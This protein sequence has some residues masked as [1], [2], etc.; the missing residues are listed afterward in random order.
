MSALKD[1]LDSKA[2]TTGLVV[3][4][5]AAAAVWAFKR[6]GAVALEKVGT[7]INPADSDNLANQAV[8][9]VGSV[10]TGDPSWS[11]GGAIFDW[12]NRGSA[13]DYDGYRWSTAE[14]R[15]TQIVQRST[16]KIF[17]VSAS[18]VMTPAT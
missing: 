4:M 15:Y 6:Y 5:L 17:N 8:T 10:L 9:G 16:G 3:A 12:F 7:A 13:D 11:L 2:I 18:G 14:G 1:V